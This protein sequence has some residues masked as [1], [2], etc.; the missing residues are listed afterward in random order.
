MAKERIILGKPFLSKFNPTINWKENT[1]KL[2]IGDKCLQLEQKSFIDDIMIESDE[3][4]ATV[5]EEGSECFLVELTKD[6]ISLNSKFLDEFADIF[7]DP[8]ASTNIKTVKH[9]ID[10]GNNAPVVKRAYRMSP[11]E[12]DNLKKTLAEYLE[13][14]Y[15]Q[16]S[17]SPWSS[18]VIFVKKKDGTLRMCVDYRALNRITKKNSYTLPR[19]DE[20]VDRIGK[21]CYFSKI[22]LKSG[23]HQ[24]LMEDSDKEKTSFATRYGHYEFC[25]LPF[26]LCNAPA[27]FMSFMNDIFHDYIDKFM[28]IYLDDILIFSNTE[29]EHFKHVQLVLERLR[30]NNLKANKTKCEFFTDKITFLGYTLSTKG[31]EP[32]SEKI[33]A[34]RDFPIPKCKKDVRSF[35]GLTSYYRK[36]IKNFSSITSPLTELLKDDITFCWTE[37]QT[38]VLIS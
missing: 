35:I 26:G 15:I 8:K 34:I 36:F 24:I 4:L 17:K 21:S 25:V 18:P 20:F 1:M 7:D 2:Y 38:A 6:Q 14:G 13:K 11:L 23:Y 12:L 31:L 9:K 3:F 30:Q 19:I 5:D 22:D 33:I 16:A 27:T 37:K 29:E 32:D 28:L 10:T